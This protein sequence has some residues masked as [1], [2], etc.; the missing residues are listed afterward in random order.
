MLSNNAERAREIVKK[1]SPFFQNK[2]DY[3]FSGCS[4]M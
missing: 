4:E 2:E 3:F 1:S